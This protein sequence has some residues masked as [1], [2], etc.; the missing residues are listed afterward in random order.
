MLH[1][2]T[3]SKSRKLPFSSL[4]KFYKHKDAFKILFR[5]TASVIGVKFLSLKKYE[6]EKVRRDCLK[7]LFSAP[8]QT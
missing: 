3:A 2:K 5:M 8:L 1:F 6:I 7:I 4:S